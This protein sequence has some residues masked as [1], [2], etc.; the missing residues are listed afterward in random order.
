M[1]PNRHFFPPVL[2]ALLFTALSHAAWN[3]KW[4]GGPALEFFPNR[5]IGATPQTTA[6]V[7]DAQGRLFVGSD[8]LLVF[9]GVNWTSHPLP[10]SYGLA[11]LCF[12]PDH[13]L[14]A[15][16]HNQIGYYTETAGGTFVFT[17]LMAKLPVEHRRL[18]FTWGC[19]LV[20]TQVFFVCQ[21]K[22]LRWD[23]TQ[24]TV[25]DFP[26][27]SRLY[28]VRLGDELWFTHLET[29]L[30]RLTA[31]GPRLEYGPQDLPKNP[32]FGLERDARGLRLF[33][34]DGLCYAGQPQ[35]Q[36]CSPE[37]VEFLRTRPLS[38]V[39]RLPE[40]D[41]AIGTLGGLGIMS[42]QGRLLRTLS[43]E[44]GLTSNSIC[45]LYLD[46]EKNLWISH[47]TGGMARLDPSGAVSLFQH[48]GQAD[49]AS[50][51]RFAQASND[52]ALF[53][54]SDAGLFRLAPDAAGGIRFLPLDTMPAHIEEVFPYR[55]GL[56][57]GRFGG[58][59]FFDG[60]NIR[61]IWETPSQIFWRILPSRTKPDVF[62]CLVNQKIV[63]LILETD[64]EWKKQELGEI[65]D[66]A[67]NC[68]L[69]SQ[70]N[71]WLNSAQSG[72][73]HFDTSSSQLTQVHKGVKSGFVTES[74][75]VTGYGQNVYFFTTREGYAAQVG[76]KEY[77]RIP[78]YP[79]VTAL[80]CTTSLD[81]R[82]LYVVFERKQTSGTV[83]GLGRLVLDESGATREW[84]EL[85]VPKLPV[86]GVPGTL[87]VTT[88]DGNDALWVG[89]SEGVVRIK[90]DELAPV[91]PPVRPWLIATETSGQSASAGPVPS[92]AFFG[93]HLVIHA[94]TAEIDARPHLLFQTRLGNGQSEWSQA[95][96]RSS[97]EFTNLIDGAYTF[98]VRA[99]NEAGL[100]S[101]PVAHAFRIL[102]PWYRTPWAYAGF[103]AALAA[104][105]FG[106]VRFHER[107]IRARNQQ[108]ES[109]VD[110]RT[111]ELVK[112]NAAK[113][114]FLAGI[115]HEIRNPMNG[116]IGIATVI[117]SSRFDP[118]TKQHMAQLR[119]CATH[120]SGLLEDIL[121]YS[122]LQAGAVELNPQPFD[123]LEMTEAISAITAAESERHGIPLEIAVSP[124]V[125]RRLIGDLARLRQIL[126]N[127][128]L[129]ALKYSGRGTVC[130][131]VWGQQTRPDQVALTFA[132][133]D[134]GP[135]ISVEEQARLF[136]RFERGA[137]AQT[138][139]VAGTG[140]GLALCKTL[141]EKMG[142]RLWVESKPG[143]G[144]T[145]YF[146]LTLPV[147][148]GAPAL[149]PPG[150]IRA[151]P[152][153][154]MHALV[155]DDEEYNR[156]T[157]SRFL[158][159]VGFRVTT[160]A[161][162][163]E[164]LDVA[165]R[166][167]LHAVFLDLNLPGMSGPEI[168]RALRAME[169][170][171]PDLSIIATTAYT[172]AEKRQE[173]VE[174]GMSAFLSKPISLDKIHAA[175]SAATSAQRPAPSFHLPG[176]N[177]RID[178][179][180]SLRLVAERKGVPL[181]AEIARFFT[182][183]ASEERLLNDALQRHEPVTASDAAHRLIGR[184]AFIQA[185]AEVQL[186]RD[187]ETNCM[188]EYWDQ[189]NASAARLVGLLPGL[190]ERIKAGGLSSVT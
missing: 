109:L 184:L 121:D 189:A 44:D 73:W 173:C 111:A 54:A 142:G 82:R 158:H 50:I 140:L 34:R 70:D 78:G 160:V 171:D 94:G 168:A 88:E 117:D 3:D 190:R 42:A 155:V 135:G 183:L 1:S 90:P 152:L 124:A 181:E 104:A 161:T 8:A 153:K 93:H 105:V 40:G 26:N 85:Q 18:E 81:G 9:D 63:K 17:S 92:Y 29:G 134:D 180:G 186:A 31:E 110:K 45:A 69:D 19:G 172:T 4:Q 141:G 95:S 22:V 149:I 147:A 107:R 185:A 145:F 169:D 86:A 126:L 113:D 150:K 170:L 130:L 162:G 154:F 72:L 23:G 37:V 14:W 98:E 46:Q 176:E 125:P 138:Q 32:A 20:G 65:P 60:K 99:V 174:A 21:S 187:I 43:Q 163:D 49:H 41:Y 16:G 114:E 15:G 128:V 6:A 118:T 35:Q 24:F 157:L 10:D 89:G 5:I 129:N 61:T 97:F 96:P 137:A 62:F 120:L 28:P 133:S 108:L 59:D 127:Y 58:L 66:L 11:A 64:R 51:L 13:K 80:Q 75:Q 178:P 39:Q 84:T 71:L 151:G 101:E 179:L 25:W 146:A 47:A 166:Q 77:R 7:Q 106:Y 56:L 53:A 122:R 52:N 144:S 165:R 76:S 2:F 167:T 87:L 12:G 48:W 83:Y 33:S 115:S 102:P 123:L 188:N 74:S 100:V 57:L 136:T 143:E 156:I 116:V 132:V 177:Q 159:E 164:A 175:L 36:L 112:A 103:A 139:R 55:N 148:S 79:E 182:E 67:N 131:T 30:Y 27:E 38:S 68:Y 91:Q 119:H